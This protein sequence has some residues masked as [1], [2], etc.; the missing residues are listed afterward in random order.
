MKSLHKLESQAAEALQEA[1]RRHEAELT[2]FETRQRRWKEDAKNR[3]THGEDLEP[4]DEPR[5]EEPKP[6]RFVVNNVTVPKLQ[7]ILA[8][9]PPGVVLI[10]D[11]LAGWLADLDTQGRESD[12]PFFLE[13]WDGDLPFTVDRITRGTVR[14][15]SLCLSLFG[16]IQ[17]DVFRRYLLGAIVGGADNDGLAQ[18]LQILVYPD[19][20]RIWRNVDRPEDEEARRAMEAVLFRIGSI[21]VEE[22]IIVR[23]DQDAQVW[24][25]Q[26]RE[27][28]ENRLLNETMPEALRSH[29]GKYR[30]LMPKVALLCHLADDDESLEVPLHQAVR[31]TQWCE[32]LEAHA[33]R[34][35]EDASP[36]SMASIL[37]EKIQAGALSQRF[38]V[39]EVLKKDWS[40]LK[41]REVVRALLQELEDARWV[42]REPV[43]ASES[44]GRPAERYLVNPK[45]PRSR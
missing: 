40:G 31:A 13:C 29:L 42:R 44:G 38:T 24:F 4:F 23:F 18:R 15:E 9:N 37:A 30:S 2:L 34:V 28:L 20:L 45:I 21:S 14:A 43:Q 3:A 26:W 19:L 10:R 8:Q 11:E 1:Y 7:E 17:P 36:R 25:N 6:K 22:P 35:Y 33:R 32:L 12:R 5:P 39:R 41:N 16:G 27:T